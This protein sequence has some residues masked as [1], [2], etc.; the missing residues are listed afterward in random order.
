MKKTL[1]LVFVIF[2]LLGC[3]NKELKPVT[4]AGETMGTYYKVSLY[5]DKESKRLKTDIDK[6]FVHFNNL[7]S[8]YIKDSEISKIN[9]SKFDKV[10]VSDSMAKILMIAENIAQKSTGYFDITVGPLVN[11]WGFGPDKEKRKRPSEKQ[12]NQ[13]KKESG[14]TNIKLQNHYLNKLVPG[15]YLDLSAIAKGFGVDELVKYLEFQ[16]Y[17]NLL[18]EIGGEVRTRGKKLDGSSWRVGIEGPGSA[19]GASLSSVVILDNMSM[20]TSGSYR[21][22]IKYGDEIFSHT[23]NPKTG[24][25][26]EHKTVSVSVVH[27]YCADADAWAT[28]LMSLGGEKALKLANENDLMAYIQVKENEEIKILMTKSYKDYIERVT[29]K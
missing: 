22:F 28:A 2:N 18:V 25:P 6:F 21:N 20:A 1:I 5:T 14:Y 24:Y 7:F 23:I 8:T 15:I 27:E 13:L 4:I 11:A 3:S 16:G 17:K 12:I 10:K 19:L 26:V 29:K 9:T